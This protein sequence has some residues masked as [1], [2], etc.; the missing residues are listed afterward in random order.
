ME[1]DPSHEYDQLVNGFHISH[2]AKSAPTPQ[3]IAYACEVVTHLGFNVPDELTS[4]DQAGTLLLE[5]VVLYLAKLEGK[6]YRVFNIEVYKDMYDKCDYRSRPEQYAH[7]K[8]MW[9]LIF[10]EQ[11]HEFITEQHISKIT[12][13]MHS[14]YDNDPEM[15]DI[16]S[17]LYK[18]ELL[19]LYWIR[20]RT[21]PF[22]GSMVS[23]MHVFLIKS[24]KASTRNCDQLIRLLDNDTV[25]DIFALV[26]DVKNFNITQNQ[27]DIINRLLG[28]RVLDYYDVIFH[29]SKPTTT[30]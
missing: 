21:E 1:V 4:Y 16:V 13:Y 23:T 28:I 3:M 10:G 5:F 26:Y 25:N 7:T 14:D 29:S 12:S 30:S 20:H 15:K 2:Y 11:M 8:I 6:K 19:A 18:C 9:Y 22:T 24:L 27:I 17:K